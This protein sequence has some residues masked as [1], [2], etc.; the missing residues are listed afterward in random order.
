VR[1]LRPLG[2][3][4][5]LDA[6]WGLFR[7]RFVP[8]SVMTLLC[9]V[10]ST[11]V[12]AARLSAGKARDQ[13]DWGSLETMLFNMGTIVAWAGAVWIIS[14]AYFG[15]R[16][17]LREGLVAG[18]RKFWSLVGLQLFTG[19]AA[20]LAALLFVVPGIV[21]FG[22]LSAATQVLVLEAPGSI[23]A[24][25]A[26]SWTLTRGRRIRMA[27]LFLLGLSI[28]FTVMLGAMIALTLLLSLAGVGDATL[29]PVYDVILPG[30]FLPALLPYVTALMTVAY[31]DLRVRQEGFDLELLARTAS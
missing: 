10:P 3:G 27:G 20:G 22:G 15:R 30:V 4:E 11:L 28:I 18:G 1:L 8:L 21:V 9:V 16:A 31:Y 23:D 25:V 13:A 2:A 12:T 7:S 24:A 14:E 19:I 5:L 6:A 29:D 17:G 26:R